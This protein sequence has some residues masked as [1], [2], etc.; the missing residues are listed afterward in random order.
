MG[1]LPTSHT[2]TKARLSDVPKEKDR[3]H[4]QLELLLGVR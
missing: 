4:G 2:H 3:L 1:T